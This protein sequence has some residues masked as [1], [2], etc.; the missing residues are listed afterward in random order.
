MHRII[1]PSVFALSLVASGTIAGAQ[2]TLNFIGPESPAVWESLIAKFQEQHPEVE[3]EYQQIP[4]SAFNAQ[5]EAR[6]GS[7]DPTI[8]VYQADTPR[9]PALASRGYLTD[10][11]EFA[12]EIRKLA[13]PTEQNSISVNGTFYALPLWTGTQL[14]YYNRDLFDQAGVEYPSD[15]PTKRMTWAEVLNMAHTLQDKSDAEFGFTF[16]QVD[17]YFQLQPLFESRGAGSGLT[18][19]DMLTPAITSEGWIETATWYQELFE[20]GLS[21][22]GISVSQMPDLFINGQ[23]AMIYGGLPL[24][25]RF[26][27][28]ENLNFGIA[29]VPYFEGGAEVTSTGSWAIGVSPYA[30]NPEEAK[31]FARFMTLDLEG[32]R[33]VSE[34]TSAVPVNSET[35][36]GYL[37]K[38]ADLSEGA[39]DAGAILSY[40][41]ENTSVPRPRSRGY[42]VFEEIMNQAF[43]DIRNGSDVRDTLTATERRLTSALSRL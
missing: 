2:T 42:V 9:V 12:D 36:K 37:G 43:S 33:L 8:D 11:S 41:I 16:N 38:L 40:E 15:D 24:V 31:A 34:N 14:M 18:G 17:R 7:K 6:V 28:A 35:Y 19:D 20:S 27:N 32:S 25:R 1:G 21:P 13:T 29:A 5:I 4:F 3:V 22:R 26:G 30:A 23:V 39:G 10:M